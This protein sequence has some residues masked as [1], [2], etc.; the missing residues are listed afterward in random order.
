MHFNNVEKEGPSRTR[1][2]RQ[3]SLSFSMVQSSRSIDKDC[4]SSLTSSS[5]CHNPPTFPIRDRTNAN[6]HDKISKCMYSIIPEFSI[7]CMISKE[8]NIY[9]K[10]DVQ[11]CL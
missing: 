2:V 9:F 7:K 8:K 5:G 4:G 6:N 3:I 11:G 10:E 1:G